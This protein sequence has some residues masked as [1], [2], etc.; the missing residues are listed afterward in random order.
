M[1]LELLQKAIEENYN[2]LSE[3]SNAAFSLDPVSDERLVE[4]AKDVNEQLGYELYDKL[5]KESLIADFS[6]TSREMY[7][8]TLDKSKFLN[9]R[10]E[11]ALVEHCDDILV[12][13]VKVYENIDNMGAYEM[14]EFADGVNKKLGYKLFRDLYSYSLRRDFERVAKAVETYKKE[15]KIT[16]FI[17]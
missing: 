15:G 11:K 7:K 13:V 2:A 5:D 8:Y 12:D 1:N 6:T 9:D 10:L 16:K 17:K 3:V 14:F 4:I